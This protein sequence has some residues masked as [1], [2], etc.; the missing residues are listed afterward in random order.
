VDHLALAVSDQERSRR[1][2]E[3]YLAFTAELEPRSDGVLMLHSAGGFSLALGETTEPISLPQFLHFGRGLSGPNEVHAFRDRLVEDDI[4]IAGFWD[5]P[6]YVSVKFRDPDG[7][8]VEV[9]WESQ[10]G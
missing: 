5:G 8:V 4:E 9:S 6:D 1:F 10:D 2:Y 7:Y 3:R